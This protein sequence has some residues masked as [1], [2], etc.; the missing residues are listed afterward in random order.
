MNYPFEAHCRTQQLC[1]ETF[2]ARTSF[3]NRTV[4][5][6]VPH[7]LIRKRSGL[8]GGARHFKNARP[9]PRLSLRLVEWVNFLIKPRIEI[10]LVGVSLLIKFGC[11]RAFEWASGTASMSGG[12]VNRLS[13]A[14]CILS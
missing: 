14:Y 8:F 9:R 12:R 4:R 10:V 11:S 1:P 7:T 6:S 5:E 3:P 13:Y 2:Y